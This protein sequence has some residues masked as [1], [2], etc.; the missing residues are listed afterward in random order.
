MNCM[1]TM[2]GGHP[3]RR[4]GRIGCREM[5]QIPAGEIGFHRYADGGPWPLAVAR[6]AFSAWASAHTGVKVPRACPDTRS[7]HPPGRT[8]RRI[9]RQKQ[10]NLARGPDPAPGLQTA[11]ELVGSERSRQIHPAIEPSR[12]PARESRPL[13]RSWPLTGFRALRIMLGRG[14]LARNGVR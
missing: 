3:L 2:T 11:P 13:I 12:T 8:R 9:Q 7:H 10:R 1:R 4:L 14:Y 5:E 6:S